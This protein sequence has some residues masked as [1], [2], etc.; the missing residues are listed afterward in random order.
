MPPI[1]RHHIQAIGFAVVSVLFLLLALEGGRP[2][3]E[4]RMIFREGKELA[5][6]AALS[7]NLNRYNIST[8]PGPIST[9]IFI[10]GSSPE[11][12]RLI[13]DKY[14]LEMDRLGTS[15]DVFYSESKVQIKN[16]NYL[17]NKYI[18]TSFREKNNFLSLIKRRCSSKPSVVVDCLKAYNSIKYFIV[19]LDAVQRLGSATTR[20][21]VDLHS[22]RAASATQTG[23]Y[24]KAKPRYYSPV[25]LLFAILS[26]IACGWTVRKKRLPIPRIAIARDLNLNPSVVVAS[27]ACYWRRIVVGA[28]VS[29][30]AFAFWTRAD[31]DQSPASVVVNMDVRGALVTT[32]AAVLEAVASRLNMS[33]RQLV[34]LIKFGPIKTEASNKASEVMTE[35]YFYPVPDVSAIKLADEVMF[36]VNSMLKLRKDDSTSIRNKII[37]DNYISRQYDVAYKNLIN[38]GLYYPN[39]INDDWIDLVSGLNKSRNRIFEEIV[40][41]KKQLNG[42]FMLSAGDEHLRYK[43]ML[44]DIKIKLTVAF[45]FSFCV[46]SAVAHQL[47]SKRAA[48]DS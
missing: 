11:D 19:L 10:E 41:E 8:I 28:V 14:N 5:L 44:V 23:P 2:S 37:L 32:D 36:S 25:L 31:Y 42:D 15:I 4:L 3:Y 34:D 47:R 1:S 43:S 29:A 48:T 12:I 30:A 24:I 18:Q 21:S 40:T 16:W 27:I 38:I 35:I 17:I 22:L 45:I 9:S 6:R 13:L 46:F 20:A 26:L 33:G 39:L 7:Q